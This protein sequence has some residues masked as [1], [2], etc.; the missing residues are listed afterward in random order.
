[1]GRRGRTHR[2]ETLGKR[3]AELESLDA[4]EETTLVF[5]SLDGT[6]AIEGENVELHPVTVRQDAEHLVRGLDSFDSG[7]ARRVE[8]RVDDLSI[9]GKVLVDSSKHLFLRV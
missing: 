3:Q 1:M 7:S 4:I 5:D 2:V 6:N 8:E 9:F